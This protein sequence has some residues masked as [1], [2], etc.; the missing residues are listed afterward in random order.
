M[1]VLHHTRKAEADDPLD[2]ISGTLGLVGC[3]DTALVLARASGGT[4]L[5]VRGR[6]LEERED[7]IV[8]DRERCIW[9][10]QGEAAE[11]R[12]SDTRKAILA[13]LARSHEPLGPKDIADEIGLHHD[14][15]RQ[16]LRR[17]TSD[18][19]VFSC[20]AENTAACRPLSRRSRRHKKPKVEQC[21]LRNEVTS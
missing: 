6:D 12:Q 20:H 14:N 19:E 3:A 8:F 15:V 18:G 1:L 9:T 17:M 10:I 11:V 2:T 5:Y 7:A 21:Q 16:T 4:T 13:V